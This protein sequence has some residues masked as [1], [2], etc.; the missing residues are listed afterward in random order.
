MGAATALAFTLARLERVDALV[1]IT[2]ASRGGPSADEEELAQWDRLARG[3]RERGVEGFLAAYDPPVE[4]RW[5]EVVLTATRQR[6]EGHADLAA[7]ADALEVVPRSAP[8]EGGLAALASLE[9][10]TFVVGSRDGADP[11]HA[12]AVAEE[13]ADT[14]PRVELAVEA[15]GESPL[16]WQGAQ[17]SRAIADFLWRWVA[18]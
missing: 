13:Y 10:P 12:L 14:L 3:L 9:V 18:E 6:L 2:P 8:W 16:A 11:G 17:L 4:E 5:R 7:L 1:Q 15:E